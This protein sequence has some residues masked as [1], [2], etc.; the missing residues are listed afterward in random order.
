[1]GLTL[2]LGGLGLGPAPAAILTL[3]LSLRLAVDEN[4]LSHHKREKMREFDENI[5]SP[6]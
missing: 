2:R 6:T 1:M 5:P 4:F 3:T